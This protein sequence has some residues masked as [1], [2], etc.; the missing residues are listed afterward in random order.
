MAKPH[1]TPPDLPLEG[2]MITCF[3]CH[4]CISGSCI[5][6]R[7]PEEMCKA[8]HNC[9]KG[10]ACIIGVA[11]LGNSPRISELIKACTKNCHYGRSFGGP[12]EHKVNIIYIVREGFKE[13]K[14]RRVV[15]INN[16]I[17]CISCHDPY[18]VENDRLSV[19]YKDN[20]L[21]LACHIK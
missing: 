21:C 6:R 3:T 11:H 2:G 18:A 19:P 10:M 4:N 14:D 8:C 5:L 13:V 17:T 7:T 12:G 15:L 9:K 1:K 20:A 16:K